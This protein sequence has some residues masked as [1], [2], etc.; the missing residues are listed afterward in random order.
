MSPA[1]AKVRSHARIEFVF[2]D[3]MRSISHEK[4]TRASLRQSQRTRRLAASAWQ[5]APDR[6]QLATPGIRHLATANT[7]TTPPCGTSFCHPTS[8]AMR[9]C[10]MAASTP[11]PDSTATYWTP[12]TVQAEGGAMTPEWVRKCQ[13]CSPVVASKARNSRSLVP[14][15]K[16]SPPAVVSSDP[17]IMELEYRFRQTRLPVLTS[18][19]WISPKKAAFVSTEK[20]RSGTA[21]PVHHCPGTRS[22][23]L[24][25]SVLQWFSL[26]GMYTRPVFGL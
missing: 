13:S 1:T 14:P 6:F 19:A 3:R 20:W 7:Q 25:S 2:E 22:S 17:H 26:D 16:T 4:S 8:S 9:P 24:P 15:P 5:L 23:T 12:S 21:T 10:F 11:Q 18:T